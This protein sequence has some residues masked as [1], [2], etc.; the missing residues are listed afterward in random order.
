[1]PTA[2]ELLE[3]ADALMRRKREAAA[4]PAPH[5][6][7][8]VTDSAFAVT[9]G[10]PTDE[11]P[12][13]GTGGSAEP[14][15][16]ESALQD[17]RPSS[18][19]GTL[20]ALRWSAPAPPAPRSTASPVFAP[21]ASTSPRTIQRE[22]IAPSVAR[23][24]LPVDPTESPLF[25]SAPA[26]RVPARDDEDI[27]VLTDA[28]QADVAD[29]DVPLLTEAVAAEEEPI[30]EDLDEPLVWTPTIG[31]ATTVLHGV[32]TVAAVAAPAAEAPTSR[33]P[34]GLDSPP[35]GFEPPAT[36]QWSDVPAA[37]DEPEAPLDAPT[38][39]PEEGRDRVASRDDAA[40]APT[41]EPEPPMPA[42][43]P[44]AVSAIDEAVA[45][46]PA[47]EPEV[48]DDAATPSEAIPAAIDSA[49][50]VPAPLDD[51]RVREIAEEIGMQVLQR[52][53]IFTD[54]ELRAKLG[55]RLKPVVDR[56][57]AD[58]VSAINQHVG[59]LL[60]AYV[61]EAIEREIDRWR[62]GRGG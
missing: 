49:A 62:E 59:E 34:L 37:P 31:G 50:A 23:T 48:P 32:P 54:T 12:V 47:V 27:P 61:A 41:P 52:V 8:P 7:G 5:A 22:P 58:L 39:M 46:G 13:S 3:Q 36:A 57:S 16:P 28:V 33:D 53:D 19:A 56:V 30:L 11:A 55:E 60:R 43:A 10:P 35:P 6:G 20:A 24:A 18:A 14:D 9:Q 51:A 15:V 17:L 1:M 29:D 4:A 42:D 38:A 25:S 44:D 40:V 21:P 26:A 2:R 45:T